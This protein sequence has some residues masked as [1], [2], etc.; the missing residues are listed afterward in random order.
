MKR[1]RFRAHLR[2]HAYRLTRLGVLA[3]VM[4]AVGFASAPVARAALTER[5]S[6]ANGGAQANGDS[7][8]GSASVSGN[9]RYVVFWSWASDLNG[10]D[11]NNAA[12]V[13]LRDRQTGR[14]E[15][16]SVA[17]D[18]AQANNPSVNA[19]I[20]ADGRYVAFGSSASNLVGGDTNNTA[21]VFV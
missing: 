15:R 5:L 8:G 10:G 7:L 18:G 1:V 12:D 20:S 21:D 19:S 2:N 13:F 3:C 14:T 6:V 11:T 9:G 4:V 17:N 16:V